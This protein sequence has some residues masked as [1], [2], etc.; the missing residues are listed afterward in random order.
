[1][2]KILIL[3]TT[4]LMTA[5]AIAGDVAI[6]TA[7]DNPR[8]SWGVLNDH[9]LYCEPQQIEIKDEAAGTSNREARPVCVG[10]ITVDRIRT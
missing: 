3:L 2:R 4:I 10:A 9:I 6:S 1:M 8:A 7:S 5:P